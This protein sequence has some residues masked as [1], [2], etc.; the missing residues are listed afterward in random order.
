MAIKKDHDSLHI[1]SSK[2]RVTGFV[3]VYNFIDKDTKQS[4]LYAPSFDLSSYGDSNEKALIMLKASL[5]D[6]FRNLLKMTK[7]ELRSELTRLG[8]GKDKFRNKDFSNS[9]VGVDGNLENFNADENKVE[10]F[11]LVA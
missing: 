11:A 3:T 8:W 7:D 10:R 2:N 9:S 6:L 1:N 5:A 4:V